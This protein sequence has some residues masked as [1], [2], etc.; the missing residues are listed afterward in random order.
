MMRM[1]HDD[2]WRCPPLTFSHGAFAA[3]GRMK[4]M[5]LGQSPQ[6]TVLS[7]MYAVHAV[8]CIILL[9]MRC[10]M[11]GTDVKYAATRSVRSEPDKFLDQVSARCAAH[12]HDLAKRS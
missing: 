4:A 10:A 2:D 11:S 3:W 5:P 8:L 9:G 6:C 1:H 7:T 12:A